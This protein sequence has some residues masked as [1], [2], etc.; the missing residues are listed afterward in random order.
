MCVCVCVCVCVLCVCVCHCV[1]MY[2]CM[3]DV[4]CSGTDMHWCVCVCVCLCVC[5]CVCVCV[6]MCVRRSSPSQNRVGADVPRRPRTSSWLSTNLK[7]NTSR[8]SWIPTLVSHLEQEL[9]NEGYGN[10]GCPNM[11][12]WSALRRGPR[13]RNGQGGVFIERWWT[14]ELDAVYRRHRKPVLRPGRDGRRTGTLQCS[15]L[16]IEFHSG[17]PVRMSNQ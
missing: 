5:V 3:Y 13:R 15:T 17:K 8:H 16:L 10:R 4:I 1:C 9:L 12:A 6:Y 7:T 14:D 2:V 11:Y